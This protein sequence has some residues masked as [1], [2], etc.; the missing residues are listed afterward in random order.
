VADSTEHKFAQVTSGRRALVATYVRSSTRL[1]A[2]YSMAWAD[3]CGAL[4]ESGWSNASRSLLAWVLDPAAV[5][6]AARVLSGGIPPTQRRA[7]SPRRGPVDVPSWATVGVQ[8]VDETVYA[9]PTLD[10]DEAE[11]ASTRQWPPVTVAAYQS[12]SDPVC[13]LVEVGA[14]GPP[15]RLVPS[16]ARQ[17][18]TALLDAAAIAEGAR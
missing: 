5:D 9:H 3:A 1:P 14:A 10:L 16:Q 11:A 2:L 6:Q 13:V 7:P 8:L 12:G 18:S 4:V 15:T 17:L